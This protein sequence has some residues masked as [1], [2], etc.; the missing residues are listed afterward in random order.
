MAKWLQLDRR[1]LRPE[2]ISAVQQ[3]VFVTWPRRWP[4]GDV[5]RCRLHDRSV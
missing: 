5:G 1:S 4:F 3:G 2:V